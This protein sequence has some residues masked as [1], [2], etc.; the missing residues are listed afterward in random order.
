MFCMCVCVQSSA[1]A[2]CPNPHPPKKHIKT[3]G[4]FKLMRYAEY[5]NPLH[6]RSAS[7][8]YD[9]LAS[10][11]ALRG[12]LAGFRRIHRHR[13]ADHHE[14]AVRNIAFGEQDVAGAEDFRFGRKRQQPQRVDIEFRQQRN[15]RQAFYV[16]I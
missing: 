12:R 7:A 14:A 5:P 8:L 16:G 1:P 6:L 13:A 9:F 2:A 4:A 11:R 10:L 15:G 3:G